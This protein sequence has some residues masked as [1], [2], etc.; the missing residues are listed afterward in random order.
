MDTLPFVSVI[1]PTYNRLDSLRRT[2]ASLE[3]QSY[4]H[5][6]F[7]VVAV[8]D[9][10]TDGTA[11]WLPTKTD[12]ALSLLHQQNAGATLAR[13]AGCESSRGDL[14]VFL[15]DDIVAHPLLV[16]ALVSTLMER[17]RTIALGHIRAATDSDAPSTF[18]RV[19]ARAL[20]PA[21]VRRDMVLERDIHAG[22][23]APFTECMTGALAVKRADFIALSM[24]Q[25]PTG[26]WPNWDD[27]DFGYRAHLAGFGFW[28]PTAA[29]AYHLDASIESLTDRCARYERASASAPLLFAT[30]PNLFVHVQ[31]FHD[32]A[33][34]RWREDSIP[35]MARKF[36][37]QA[38]SARPLVAGLERL[39]GLQDHHLRAQK[40]RRGVYQLGAQRTHLPRVPTG[41]WHSM[42]KSVHILHHSISPFAGQYPEGDP[43]HYNSGIPM[44]FG[45]AIRQRY[46]EAQVEVWRPERTLASP[47]V[48]QDEDQ[49]T[50]RVYPSIYG[51]FNVELS[52]PLLR[53]VRETASAEPET[54]F[55]VHGIYNLHA[56]LLA[57]MLRH[58]RV[59]A[60]SH[61]GFPARAMFHL[62]RHRWLRYA[63]LPL[64]LVERRALPRYRALFALSE[65]EERYLLDWLRIAPDAVRVSPTGIDFDHFCPG[66]AEE[67]RQRC[68]LPPDGAIVLYVG[69]LAPEKGL[70]QLLRAFE[71]VH[72]VVPDARLVLVGTGP[73][74]GA[75]QGLA[76]ELG[77]ASRAIFAG[78]VPPDHLPDWYRAASVT[79]I[80]SLIEWFG[81]VA[82]ESLGCGTP[83]VITAGG[84]AREIVD[85]FQCGRLV[86]P[87]DHYGLADAIC[88]TLHEPGACL[89]D[90]HRGREAYG[91]DA[92][93]RLAFGVLP[94]VPGH[95]TNG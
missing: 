26:A 27:L 68:G 93:L 44:L 58:A 90:I 49:I 32:K 10:S 79:V 71:L 64:H 39:A 41:T 6:R 3:Q 92:K 59:I 67:A 88:T 87:G 33:P 77:V 30:H 61:G 21:E 63:Y 13:N 84:A 62:S 31:M 16:S 78:Y 40:L 12:L 43:L 11:T 29:V 47:Q 95:A 55:W 5:D 42:I 52:M 24:F 20:T 57:G 2:L 91:W 66:D 1:I 54:L 19:Y 15:D 28:R 45:R 86:S 46:P 69:R 38:L 85:V 80:P 53:A 9:G 51:R 94:Q 83:I 48:W 72:S 36:R 14:L 18:A 37:R 74:Q 34:I 25:D 7:E 4:P 82:P 23:P 22:A 76:E 56:Y 60:Q 50:H 81:K 35:N 8:D 65:E 70:E 89:P 75:L 73:A 17:E